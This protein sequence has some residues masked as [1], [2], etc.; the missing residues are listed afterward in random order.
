MLAILSQITFKSTC[1]SSL[2]LLKAISA[3]SILIS[4]LL[5]IL[6]PPNYVNKVFTHFFGIIVQYYIFVKTV[7]LVLFMLIL[8]IVS[9]IMKQ[10]F[11]RVKNGR[12][13]KTISRK[14]RKNK[15]KI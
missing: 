14:Y 5:F 3:L 10:N 9:A 4:F 6:T 11:R 7:L 1:L 8:S 2:W 13:I 15:R 12:C